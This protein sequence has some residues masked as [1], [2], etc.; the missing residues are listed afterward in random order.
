MCARQKTEALRMNPHEKHGRFVKVLKLVAAIDRSAIN[1]GIDPHG[2]AG[3]VL[4]A[5]LGWGDAAWLQ[6]ARLANV[7]A[8][9]PTTRALVIDV[10]RGRANAPIQR[11][12]S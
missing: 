3:Q 2:N 11:R 8:P 9:S 12:A 6:I 1:Q 5:A 7:N 10:F 4:L